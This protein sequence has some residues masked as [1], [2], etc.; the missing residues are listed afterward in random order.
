MKRAMNILWPSFLAAGVAEVLFFTAFDPEAFELGRL[1]GYSI[2]FFGFW[3]L[4]AG[5]SALTCFLQRSADEVNRCPLVATQ[6][7]EGCPKREALD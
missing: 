1:A 5:S 3:A 6:R 7:P 4:A 2:G